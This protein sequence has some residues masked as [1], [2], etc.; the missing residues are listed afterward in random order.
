MLFD[1]LLTNAQV[2]TPTGTAVGDIGIIDGKIVALGALSGSEAAESID[3]TG[4]TIIPGFID[5][6]VHFRE[7]GLEHKEDLE[8][9]TRAA[10]MGGVTSILEMPNTSPNTTDAITLQDKLNRAAGRAWSNYG[11]FIGASTENADQ[12][13]ELELLPGC[14]GIKIFMGSSTGSLLVSEE[15]DLRKVLRNGTRPC[16]IHAEDE[17]RNR[18]RKSLIS[19]EPSAREHPFLRD[20]ESA[21]MATR[22]ILRLSKE[23]GR[24][25]HVLHISTKE[26]PWIIDEAR[27]AGV[28]ATSEVT[29]QHLYF[30][31]PDCYDRLGSLAQMNPPI[32]SE[33]DRAGLWRALDEGLFD[34]FGSDHA[35][36]TLEEKSKP[37]PV[38]PSGMPGVQTLLPVL[39]TFV[40]QGR[41]TLET[42]VRMSSSRPA[43]L[44]NIQGKGSIAVGMD[45]DLTI[46][47]LN[48][49]WTFERAQVES[50][51]GWSPYEGETFIGAVEHVILGGSV[52]VRSGERIAKPTGQMLEFR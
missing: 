23:T 41:L 9:G 10:L 42:L 29:P 25:V 38:S 46:V 17:P 51:C 2:V 32:R 19:E 26:E 31:G 1:L 16:P 36:H 24:P 20:S 30:A 21:I 37:Y 4:L 49:K 40:A 44:Y 27:K 48:R 43:E 7:P 52:A 28:R 34:V 39:L 50:K 33:E 35:P 18:A 12:L 11:F 22:Q 47:D 3:C 5:T 13:G 6:Q 8:S 45:A 15:D 14:P